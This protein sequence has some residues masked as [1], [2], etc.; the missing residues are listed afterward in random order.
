MFGKPT[1]AVY[2]EDDTVMGVSV[3]PPAAYVPVLGISL[4]EL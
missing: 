1:K 3:A 2:S 4:F